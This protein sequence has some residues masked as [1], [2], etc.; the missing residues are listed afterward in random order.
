MLNWCFS[1]L[2]C[3][4]VEG[5]RGER[6]KRGGFERRG[7]LVKRFG[8]PRGLKEDIIESRE[9]ERE[10]ASVIEVSREKQRLWLFSNLS[11]A[12]LSF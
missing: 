3:N 2:M 12:V 7:G 6:K 4:T 8:W 11:T 9:R 1:R 5:L 10:G